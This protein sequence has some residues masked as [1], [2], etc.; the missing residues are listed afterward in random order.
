MM[1]VPQSKAHSLVRSDL[2]CREFVNQVIQS[3]GSTIPIINE[4][5]WLVGLYFFKQGE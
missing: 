1:N 4:S 5:F 2:Y 3:A